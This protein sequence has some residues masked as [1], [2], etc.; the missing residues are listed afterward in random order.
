[1]LHI[2]LVPVAETS[3]RPVWRLSVTVMAPVVAADPALRTLMV[4]V[5]TLPTVNVP[6]WNLVIAKSGWAVAVGVE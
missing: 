4:Y 6:V 2:Q 1:V 3:V 5:S